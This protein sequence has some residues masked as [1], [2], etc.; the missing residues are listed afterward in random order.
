[1]MVGMSEY[2]RLLTQK[3]F[4]DSEVLLLIDDFHEIFRIRPSSL[5]VNHP[6]GFL[7]RSAPFMNVVL[8]HNLSTK[9]LPQY[10]QRV[11]TTILDWHFAQEKHPLQIQKLLVTL[12][13]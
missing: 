11:C 2:V 6:E 4:Q 12:S 10:F 13:D 9:S 3:I 1:M 7:A 5:E 8:C